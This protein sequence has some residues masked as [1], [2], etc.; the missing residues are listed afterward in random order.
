MTTQR[1]SSRS[2]LGVKADAARHSLADDAIYEELR[3]QAE[4]RPG[5][6]LHTEA[7]PAADGSPVAR[8]RRRRAIARLR[9]PRSYEAANEYG[10][11]CNHSNGDDNRNDA[12]RNPRLE[13]VADDSASRQSQENAEGWRKPEPA[14]MPL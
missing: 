3:H 2:G 1:M 12:G 9:M 14:A 4:A 5:P 11:A 8:P 6:A 10:N 13:Y 7:G